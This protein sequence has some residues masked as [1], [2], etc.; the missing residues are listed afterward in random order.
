MPDE[1]PVTVTFT[2]S[3]AEALALAQL[4]KR[5]GWSEWRALSV[6]DGEAYA[7]RAATDRLAAGLAAAGFAPR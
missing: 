6:D 4:A 3:Q 5:I 2:L 1:S 7:M